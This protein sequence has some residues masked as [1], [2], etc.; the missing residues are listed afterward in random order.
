MTRRKR[1]EGR[2]M[3]KMSMIVIISKY[4]SLSFYVVLRRTHQMGLAVF[5][6]KRIFLFSADYIMT[7]ILP[8]AFWPIQKV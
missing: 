4:S 1:E 7:K 3:S 2:S 8:F 6:E 5:D